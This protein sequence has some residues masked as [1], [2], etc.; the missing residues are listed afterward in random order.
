MY[1]RDQ[2]IVLR[3]IGRKGGLRSPSGVVQIWV[4]HVVSL[5]TENSYETECLERS[6]QKGTDIPWPTRFNPSIRVCPSGGVLIRVAG[7][8]GHKENFK[9]CWWDFLKAEILY[10]TDNHVLESFK[11]LP[12]IWHTQISHILNTT[13]QND[14]AVRYE[15][16]FRC[17]KKNI[18]QFS[19]KLFFFAK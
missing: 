2:K 16:R 19:L 5:A 11:G 18:L 6:S 7:F 9:L 14:H 15:S 12:K 10:Q 1:R 17:W 13:I 8:I 4:A 3:R